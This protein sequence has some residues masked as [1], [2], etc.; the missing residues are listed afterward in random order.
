[1]GAGAFSAHARQTGSAQDV[2]TDALV[3]IVGAEARRRSGGAHGQTA[4]TQGGRSRAI[5]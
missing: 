4:V 3:E 5:S 1:M 2:S